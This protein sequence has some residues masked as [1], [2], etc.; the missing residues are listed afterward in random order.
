MEFS[1]VI[2]NINSHVDMAVLT[3]QIL[4]AVDKT[5]H[6]EMQIAKGAWVTIVSKNG[7]TV[8]FKRSL[9]ITSEDTKNL[10]DY[11]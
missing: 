4:M 9:T 3:N 5:T 11:L 8:F 10:A 6:F 1:A 2:T 7:V